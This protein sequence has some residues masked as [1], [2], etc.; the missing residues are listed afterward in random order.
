MLAASTT[1]PNQGIAI[2]W[3]LSAGTIAPISRPATMG[4]AV[5]L[6]SR[7][8][9]KDLAPAPAGRVY[10]CWHTR[11]LQD[12]DQHCVPPHCVVLTSFHLASPL[13][14]NDAM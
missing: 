12:V 1:D 2:A 14:P 10:T 4:G 8:A 5:G 6:N 11:P 3:V 9:C 7:S 13:R